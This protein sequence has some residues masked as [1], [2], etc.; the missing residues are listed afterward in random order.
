MIKIGLY[1]LTSSLARDN[2][3]HLEKEQ[4]VLLIR[5]LVDIGN[6]ILERRAGAGC[7]SVPVSEPVMRA[8]VAIAEQAEDPFRGICLVTLTEIRECILQNLVD[9]W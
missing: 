9:Y 7:G 2:K 8:V 4:V 1:S 6:S 5:S 3:H